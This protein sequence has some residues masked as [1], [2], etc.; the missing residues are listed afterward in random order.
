MR[1]VIC[2]DLWNTLIVSKG[3]NSYLE[4]LRR[5]GA[6]WEK[7]YPFVRDEL[8]TKKFSYLEMTQEL[9]KKFALKL[10]AIQT[11]EV[12]RCWEKDNEQAEWL[13]GRLDWLKDWRSRGAKLV[14]V[15]NLTWPCWQ[16]VNVKLG[17]EKYFDQLFLSCLEG[18]SKPNEFV[19]KKIENI[20][21][22]EPNEFWM[23][24]DSPVDDLS[25][26]QVRGWKTIQ[27]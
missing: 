25:I 8:M 27:V 24:G 12:V 11:F 10:T 13:S 21:S 17:L 7:I 3:N 5:A 18:V 6:D 22:D 14:L 20:F 2:F 15:S 4:V 1:Q 26:P 19:W 9:N 16:T 23:V